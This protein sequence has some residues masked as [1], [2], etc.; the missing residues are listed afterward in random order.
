M[1]WKRKRFSKPLDVFF[2]LRKMWLWWWMVLILATW[3]LIINM[4]SWSYIL[5]EHH[6]EVNLPI[7][8][9]LVITWP[10]TA[11]PFVFV[12]KNCCLCKCVIG[13]FYWLLVVSLAILMHLSA[14][15]PRG[16]GGYPGNLRIFGHLH[17]DVYKSPHPKPKLFNE[18]LLTPLPWGAKKWVLPSQK[19]KYFKRVLFSIT[20]FLFA[21]ITHIRIN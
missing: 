18:K 21:I 16:R 19:V 14:A 9:N 1:K 3:D 20:N 15:I 7:P 12:N 13:F 5:A 8:E 11:H 6:G 10:C 17:N 2:F 4:R